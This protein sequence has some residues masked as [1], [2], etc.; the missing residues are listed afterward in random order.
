M[1][2]KDKSNLQRIVDE[3]EVLISK[4]YP[5]LYSSTFHLKEDTVDLAAECFVDKTDLKYIRKT[6]IY[7]ALSDMP[8]DYQ[9]KGKLNKPCHALTVFYRF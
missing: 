4:L 6:L 2:T 7:N 1:K 3:V 5:V 9:P 8:L